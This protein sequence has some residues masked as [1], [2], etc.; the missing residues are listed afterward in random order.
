MM[1]PCIAPKELYKSGDITPLAATSPS[2]AASSEPT[3]GIGSPGR[4]ICQRIISIKK[5]PNNRNVSAVMAY[6]TPMT[7]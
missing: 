1:V 4:A 2:T 5:K 3:M 7:L 6:C